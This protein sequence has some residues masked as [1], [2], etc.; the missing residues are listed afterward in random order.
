[1][2]EVF[3][4]IC[5]LSVPDAC[6]QVLVPSLAAETESACIE[7]I[8]MG[9]VD[10]QTRIE[11]LYE[12][13]STKCLPR[14]N[15]KLEFVEISK[16]VFVHQGQIVDLTPASRGNISNIG[17]IVGEES[18]AVIDSGG[19][20]WVGEQIYFAIRQVSELPISHVILTHM[21]PDHVYGASVFADQGAEVVGHKKLDQSLADR[22]ESYQ[23]SYWRLLDPKDLF[24]SRFVETDIAVDDKVVL[25][26]G[27][28][29]LE[30]MAWTLAHSNSDLTVFD[31][32][33]AI[34]F[35]GDL[36]FTRFIP[37][38]D[39]SLQGWQSVLEELKQI[40]AKLIVPGH[41][42]PVLDWPDGENEQRRYFGVL[43][44]DTRKALDE[45]LSLSE[46]AEVIGQSEAEN[47]NLFE[48]FNQRN[49]ITV[50]TELEW[51]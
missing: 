41:G 27:Y 15:S 42:G 23:T 20:R 30:L 16:G 18:I 35:V 47:W 6:E 46:A 45:G 36:V 4:T 28:R 13:K 14:P 38:V 29:K 33:S 9:V 7:S 31:P 24:T 11:D 21:H 49:A 8:T 25:D 3:T 19:S 44:S 5:L 2:F 51:E 26:L 48:E 50:Y 32:D 10:W 37:V 40:P 1:M 12:V 17:F 43:I 34:M 22:A 39:G